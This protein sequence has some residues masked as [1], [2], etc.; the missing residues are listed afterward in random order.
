MRARTWAMTAMVGLTMALLPAVG[1]LPTPAHAAGQLSMAVTGSSWFYPE[2]DPDVRRYAVH[3]ADDGTI[4]VDVT[5]SE[6]VWFN[7]VPDPDGSADFTS[8]RPG[9]EISVFTDDGAGNRRAFALYVL[10]AAF[11]KLSASR[12]AAALAPGNIAVNLNRFDAGSPRYDAILDRHGVPVHTFEHHQRALD[13]KMARSGDFTVHRPTTSPGRSGYALVVLDDQF[14]ETRRIETTGLVQTDDHDSVL[15]RD[16]SRWLTAY[17]PNAQTGLEDSIIQHVTPDGQVDFEW[18]SAPYAAETVTPTDPDYAHINSIDVQPNGDVLASFR[19]LSS[20]FLI[21]SRAHDGHQPGD[22]IW[23]LGGRDSDFTFPSGD[24][25]PCA[26]HSA[27]ILPNGNVLMFDNGST[28][29]FGRLCVD[30]A[31]PAGPPVSRQ[32]T[33]VVEFKLSGT[34]AEP[35][36]TYGPSGR[37]SWFMGSAARV[38]NGNVLIGWSADGTAM[39]SETD[40]SGEIIWSL[41]DERFS[42]GGQQPRHY[43]SY[44]AALVPERDGFDPEVTLDGPVDG[45]SVPQGA[46][47]PVSFACEDRGGSTLQTCVGPAGRRLD[48]TTPGHHTWQVVARD[49]SGRRTT[50]TRT[51]TVVAPAPAP[52]PAIPAVPPVPPVPAVP[53]TLAGPRPDLA[54]RPARGSWVGSRAYSPTRQVAKVDLPRAPGTRVVVLRLTN[55][56]ETRGRLWLRGSDT[57]ANGAVVVSYRSD[58]KDRTRAVSRGW[59]TPALAPGQSVRIRAQ[60]TAVGPGAD[61]WTLALRSGGSGLRDLVLLVPRG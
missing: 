5:G 60:I 15:E 7:G 50:V 24:G 49:G 58:G 57:V 53:P 44:R 22:V 11:P 20:V 40:A 10:P 6:H 45:L 30:P 4:H 2:F 23:K 9:D 51:Y 47:V 27:S 38:A 35:V 28:E 59:R 43:I 3:P 18:S 37:F 17:E 54:V 55:R 56:G 16:G 29:F 12:T 21:A 48:T 42:E 8:V 46:E 61:R 34:A 39:T 25:G 52:T 19:H 14:R 26:Q 31:A 41:T 32:T 1:N 13:F 33:R 36:R